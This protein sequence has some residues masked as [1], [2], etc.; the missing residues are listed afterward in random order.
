MG[1]ALLQLQMFTQ[2][3]IEYVIER[4]LEEQSQEEQEADAHG[5][6]DPVLLLHRQAAR[7]RRGEPVDRLIAKVNAAEWS[8][9]RRDD[10]TALDC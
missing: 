7:I 9:A 4:R 2:P 8:K 3:R 5:E 6:D 1:N 10:S